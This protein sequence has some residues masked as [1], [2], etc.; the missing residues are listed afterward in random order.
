M[1]SIAHIWLDRLGVFVVMVA[2]L[3]G[4]CSSYQGDIPLEELDR[5]VAALLTQQ[6][7][8]AESIAVEMDYTLKSPLVELG[9][10]LFFDKILSGNQNISCATCHHPSLASGDALSLPLGVG[11]RGLGQDRQGGPVIPRNAPEIFNRNHPAWQSMFWDSRAN[12]EGGHFY[13]P[14]HQ[15]LPEGLTSILAVQAM[16][17]VTS[18]DE[19]R[20]SLTDCSPSNELACFTNDDFRGIWQALMQRLRDIPKYQPLFEAAYGK[21]MDEMSFVE[22]ANA[23]AAFEELAF[24]HWDSPFDRYVK[25]DGGALNWEEK[26]GAWIFFS[27]RGNC[28]SCHT[29]PLFSDQ[30]HYNLA[31]PHISPGK[32]DHYQEFGYL[33]SGRYRETGARKDLFA[34]RTPPLRNIALTGPYMHNGAYASLADSIRHHLNPKASLDN[35]DPSQL[36]AAARPLYRPELNSLI[37]ERIDIEGRYLS[38]WEIDR[39]VDFLNSLSS[40]KAQDLNYLVPSQVPSALPVSD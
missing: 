4:G 33:D 15:Q 36:S 2:L 7:V 32:D 25:G 11:A 24:S 21:P 37:S 13:S 26:Y 23:I 19:M 17:P 10:M 40:P 6:Q 28:S 9:Q 12:R 31:L 8:T 29:W 34:F 39:L 35:Y 22:V 30:Q 27:G 14:A 1:L 20:G 18:R 38:D 5:Q 16:F 3:L